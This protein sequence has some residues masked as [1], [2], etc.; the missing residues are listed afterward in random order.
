MRRPATVALVLV[1]VERAGIDAVPLPRL[2]RA[3]REDVAEMAAAPRARDLDPVHAVTE[4]IVKLDVG[5]VCGLSEARPSGPRVKL[6][7]GGEQLS[8]TAGASVCAL[9]LL[10][11][12]LSGERALGPLA[13]KHLVLSR[14][15]LLAPFAVG[16]LAQPNLGLVLSVSLVVHAQFDPRDPQNG[17]V[18]L[19]QPRLHRS[20]DLQHVHPRARR[21]E[22]MQPVQDPA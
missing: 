15:E 8:A 11:E 6:R 21:C 14:G 22:P 13:A 2:A 1:E 7:I 20:G 16:L 10:V 3:I 17:S 5:A 19:G 18:K 9:S 12:V 4:V